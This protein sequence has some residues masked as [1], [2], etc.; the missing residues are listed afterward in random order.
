LVEAAI[1]IVGVF[2]ALVMRRAFVN[3]AYRSR[4]TWSGFLLL[5]LA[6]GVL[7][8]FISFPSS[9]PLSILGFLPVLAALLIAFTIVD[10]SVVVAMGTDFFHRNT[11]DWL[12]VR[13]PAALALTVSFVSFTASAI[14][15]PPFT[16][17]PL[18]SSPLWE[19]VGFY[20]FLVVIPVVYSYSATALILA[21]RRTSD[22]TLKRNIRF[23]GLALGK[24]VI[25]FVLTAPFPSDSLLYA[26]LNNSTS[27]LS[28]FLLYKSVMSLS[29]IAK[30][31]KDYVAEASGL[32]P[33]GVALPK[34]PNAL[35]QS[36]DGC[37]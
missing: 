25:N 10:R 13:W 14:F 16:S 12:R 22:R 33:T 23:L 20:Q 6:I 29:P 8:S 21:A 3:H 27:M 1:L 30:V 18:P 19:L 24:F 35:P 34:R 11:L 4:A 37:S 5:V 31:E 7:S 17:F 26:F 36:R 2:R 28:Y 15:L 9:G 32:K